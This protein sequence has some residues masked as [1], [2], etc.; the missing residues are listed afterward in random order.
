MKQTDPTQAIRAYKPDRCVFVISVD[1]DGKPNGMIAGWNMKCSYDPPLFAVALSGKGNTQKLIRESGEFVIAVPNKSLEE[2]VKF[3]GSVS[4]SK[5]DK[6]QESGIATLEAQKVKSP[7]LKDATIN[8]ECKL[9]QEV[10]AGDH[11]IFI[12]EVVAAHHAEGK[13]ALFYEKKD[14]ERIF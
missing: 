1:S 3:F 9:H 7:L 6:F 2:E 11:I 10:E 8:Y 4:G 14:G 12:G 13:K 5:I